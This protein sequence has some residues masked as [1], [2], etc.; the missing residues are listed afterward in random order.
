MRSHIA[1]FP[2]WLLDAA[3]QYSSTSFTHH[4]FSAVVCA[5]LGGSGIAGSFMQKFFADQLSI[6]Y[7][8]CKDYTLPA[9]VG[10]DTLVICSSHSGNTEETLST[11]AQARDAGAHVC[12][13]TAGG[14]LL[15]YAQEQHLD[16]VILPTGMMPRACYPYGIVAQCAILKAYGLITIDIADMFGQI[17]NFL[18]QEDAAIQTQAQQIAQQLVGKTPELLTDDQCEPVAVRFR[19]QL[20][21]NSKILCRN[22]AVPEQNH[23]EVL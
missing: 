8:V 7:I 12:C 9:F 1:A 15:Q 5:G 13:L 18:T 22:N 10:P 2:S 3:T 14:K 11:F 23:N 17:G 16:H 4:K 6:P 21:E 19:Q 20:N